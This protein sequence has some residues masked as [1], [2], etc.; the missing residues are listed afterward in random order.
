[1]IVGAAAT[2]SA[3]DSAT[4]PAEKPA[5]RVEQVELSEAITEAIRINLQIA[6]NASRKND[7]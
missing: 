7:K 3:A 5:L 4:Q 2:K 1:M 6:K